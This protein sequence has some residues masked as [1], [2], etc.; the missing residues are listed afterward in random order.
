ME[1]K[2]KFVEAR[3]AFFNVLGYELTEAWKNGLKHTEDARSIEDRLKHLVAEGMIVA[4]V[5][6]EKL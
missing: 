2:D 5:V 3:N 1:I 6:E 4:K